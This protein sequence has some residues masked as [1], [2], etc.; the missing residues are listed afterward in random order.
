MPSFDRLWEAVEHVLKEVM[1]EPKTA[2][3]KVSVVFE[4]TN[5]AGRYSDGPENL[6]AWQLWLSEIPFR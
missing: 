3:G 1:I 5:Y 6:D 4:E 2:G